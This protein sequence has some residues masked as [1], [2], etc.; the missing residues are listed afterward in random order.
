[1]LNLEGPAHVHITL[2]DEA[3][4]DEAGSVTPPAPCPE[5]VYS[6]FDPMGI[7]DWTGL[8]R[9]SGVV[10][11]CTGE[12]AVPVPVVAP[13][14]AVAVGCAPPEQAVTSTRAD[15]PTGSRES[16]IR[17]SSTHEWAM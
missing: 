17:S 7:G 12:G 1:M 13:W 14:V 2:M 8:G 3:F 9:R 16:F 11:V 15:R 5:P 6:V 10:G 4:P